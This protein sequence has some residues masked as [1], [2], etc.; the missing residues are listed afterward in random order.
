MNTAPKLIIEISNKDYAQGHCSECEAF[1]SF[2]A[3]SLPEEALR[4]RF[5]EH[6]NERHR[7]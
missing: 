7:R 5:E 2:Q 6:L 4:R 1:F 3:Q